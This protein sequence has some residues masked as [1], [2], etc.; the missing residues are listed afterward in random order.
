MSIYDLPTQQALRDTNLTWW[1]VRNSS[2]KVSEVPVGT[3]T[4]KSIM[5]LDCGS[6]PSR[7]AIVSDHARCFPHKRE[8]YTYRMEQA[9]IRRRKA[10]SEIER[11]DAII[12][13]SEREGA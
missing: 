5:R 3:V 13:E 6:R 11:M 9:D 12:L 10:I 7:Q 1:E 8:A 2:L 4:D